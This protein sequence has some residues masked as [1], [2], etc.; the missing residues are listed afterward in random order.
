[1]NENS[2]GI[3]CP[4]MCWLIALVAAILLAL[5]LVLIGGWSFIGSIFLSLIFFVLGGTLLTMFICKGDEASMQSGTTSAHSDDTGT[6][7][8]VETVATSTAAAPAATASTSTATSAAAVGAAAASSA[9]SVKSDT[10]L[11]GED[12]LASRKGEW[13]YEGEAAEEKPKKKPAAKKKPAK[14]AAPKKKAAP[15]KEAQVDYDGDG[16]FEGKDEGTRPA[17]LDGPRDGK[18][19]DLKKIKGVGPKMEKLCNSLG[20]YHFDQIASWNK[21]EVAWV[22]ANLEGFKGRVTRDTWVEQ[23]KLLAAGKETAFSKKVDK[24]GV[25]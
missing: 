1:M 13:K 24:G 9:A 19:D 18:A 11:A 6:D 8:S 23:A 16:V 22:D 2:N 10:T 17:A 20:F 25:Y 21:A 4:M 14:K 15:A 3:S 5:L 7:T 12:E